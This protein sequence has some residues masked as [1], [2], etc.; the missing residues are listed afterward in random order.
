MA[1]PIAPFALAVPWLP[2]SRHPMGCDNDTTNLTDATR[3][4]LMDEPNLLL[5]SV[6]LP[7]AKV[8][9]AVVP[10]TADRLAL[11]VGFML[12]VYGLPY[13]RVY[14]ARGG[15]HGFHMGEPAAIADLEA[16]AEVA[17]ARLRRDNAE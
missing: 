7:H 2:I 15:L 12:H 9:E 4:K 17:L 6:E 8:T 5:T 1:Q 11:L 14:T 13:F 10:A 3:V 16:L